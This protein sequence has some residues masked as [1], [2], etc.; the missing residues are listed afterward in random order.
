LRYY[1]DDSKQNLKGWLDLP[2]SAKAPVY[3]EK[4][5]V[6]ALRLPKEVN[7]TFKN[8]LFKKV[9]SNESNKQKTSQ[10]SNPLNSFNQSSQS[11]S[12]IRAPSNTSKIINDGNSKINMQPQKFN[13]HGGGQKEGIQVNKEKDNLIN[14]GEEQK[15]KETKENKESKIDPFNIN[16]INFDEIHFH[17]DEKTQP[18][19]NNAAE[20]T[21]N[22]IFNIFSETPKTSHSVSP[23]KEPTLK[24]EF[25][26]ASLGLNFEPLNNNNN[27]KTEEKT[28]TNPQSSNSDGN[29][30][31]SAF[32]NF[33]DLP[34]SKSDVTSMDQYEIR[35]SCDPIIDHWQKEGF[36]KKN[37]RMLL[38]TLHEI[39]KGEKWEKVSLGDVLED[40]QLTKIYKKAILQVHPD[41]VHSTDVRMKYCAERV[42]DILRESYSEFKK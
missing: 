30:K 9:S 26:I 33:F 23:K 29:L 35:E 34:P 2:P 5:Y 21:K 15:H 16:N 37:I 32:Q 4:I 14:F 25:D 10:N 39:W 12:P 36:T 19:K 11:K 13:S 6:K 42:Y 3:N 41:K 20:N 17:D 31:H 8:D 38:S 27:N 40:N 7:L 18:H 1:I 28:V 22:D 24:S